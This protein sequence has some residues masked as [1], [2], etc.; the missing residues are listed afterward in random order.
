VLISLQRNREAAAEPSGPLWVGT[1]DM[2]NL[3]ARAEINDAWTSI[4]L[5]H[6]CLAQGKYKEAESAMFDAERHYRSAQ[7]VVNIKQ[8]GSILD[9]L[10]D[11]R[12]RLY[13]I[14]SVIGKGSKTLDGAESG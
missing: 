14:R 6:A 12:V 1:I 2:D 4:V 7:S 13:Q 3:Q 8:S 10:A 5:A 9:N 11:L